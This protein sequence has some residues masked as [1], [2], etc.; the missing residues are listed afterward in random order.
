M[1]SPLNLCQSIV[2]ELSTNIVRLRSESQERLSQI[3]RYALEK[4]QL[5][6]DMTLLRDERD[7]MEKDK[8]RFQNDLSQKTDEL[9]E[10]ISNYNL[11]S[12]KY[13]RLQELK[14]DLELFILDKSDEIVAIDNKAKENKGT[15]RIRTRTAAEE[16]KII[17]KYDMI[18]SEFNRKILKVV[19]ECSVLSN[20]KCDSIYTDYKNA[21]NKS[22]CNRTLTHN[23]NEE[24]KKN[25][26]SCIDSR[27]KHVEECSE[28]GCIDF[29]H[30]VFLIARYNNLLKCKTILKN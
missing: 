10:S 11:L 24:I 5:L 17:K 19:E 18:A 8:N 15:P 4:D 16:E 29:G 22:A 23:Q 26:E 6:N 2:R 3:Q 28:T 9:N 20:E 7:E 14:T 1:A 13:Q 21:C 25:L 12:Q 27:L 30:V